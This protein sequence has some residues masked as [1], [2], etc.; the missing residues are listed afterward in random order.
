MMVLLSKVR[1]NEMVGLL[2]VQTSVSARICL[3]STPSFKHLS[4]NLGLLPLNGSTLI[5][6]RYKVTFKAA[7]MHKQASFKAFIPAR[8]YAPFPG[9]DLVRTI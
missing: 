5:R 4:H 2:R 7:R 9:L 3:T 8:L 1:L 6:L